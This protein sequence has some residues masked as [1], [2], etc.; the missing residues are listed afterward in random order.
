MS[1]HAMPFRTVPIE[2][3]R[4]SVSHKRSRGGSACGA[5][6]ALCRGPPRRDAGWAVGAQGGRTCGSQRG[7]QGVG[8]C[9][10]LRHPSHARCLKEMDAL[11]DPA[12][13]GFV[14]HKCFSSSGKR[15]FFKNLHTK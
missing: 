4:L 8:G 3:A 13:S 14:L 10:R 15:T 11:S 1:R 5:A 12:E 6:S 7:K 9:V 2:S